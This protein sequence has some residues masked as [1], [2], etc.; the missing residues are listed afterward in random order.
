MPCYRDGKLLVQEFHA[1]AK[2]GRPRGKRDSRLQL[3][4]DLFRH[5]AGKVL[6]GKLHAAVVTGGSVQTD[7]VAIDPVLQ[8][9]L[10]VPIILFV[11]RIPCWGRAPKMT[12]MFHFLPPNDLL[13]HRSNSP[14]VPSLK[15]WQEPC[16][17]VQ[18]RWLLFFGLAGLTQARCNAPMFFRRL[19]AWFWP[20]RPL[21]PRKAPGPMGNRTALDLD[22]FGR[23]LSTGKAED[24]KKIARDLGQQEAVPEVRR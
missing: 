12:L 6:R 7:N 5:M 2:D 15:H 23:L 24:L 19:I 8:I 11:Q 9:C 14:G 13:W 16:Q 17:Q 10:A 21:P 18:G 1:A 3:G 4:R 22:E 20:T